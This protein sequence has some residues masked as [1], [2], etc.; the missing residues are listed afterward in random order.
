[1][2]KN[3]VSPWMARFYRARM[4][5]PMYLICDAAFYNT[6]LH[7]NNDEFLALLAI[8]RLVKRV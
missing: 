5:Q 2:Y 3:N 1:M 6:Y 4:H 7:T 8:G